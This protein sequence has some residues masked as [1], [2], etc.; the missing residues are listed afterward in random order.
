M[1][2]LAL[3][4]QHGSSPQG[5]WYWCTNNLRWR[6]SGERCVSSK[7]PDPEG[8]TLSPYLSELH[9][10]DLLPS[11]PSVRGLKGAER[12]LS[13]TPA[14]ILLDIVKLLTPNLALRFWRNQASNS[15]SH[16]PFAQHSLT[17]FIFSFL[18][19][20]FKFCI[21]HKKEVLPEVIGWQSTVERSM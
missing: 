6:K 13:S 20:Q 11:C 2:F 14:H 12:D 1:P 7:K 16:D 10:M 21:S 8:W 4:H 3:S 19:I 17:L 18:I 9:L 15:K 5:R